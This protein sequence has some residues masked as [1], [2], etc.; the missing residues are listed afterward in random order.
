LDRG[1]LHS[2]FLND[3]VVLT[4]PARRMRATSISPKFKLLGLALRIHNQRRSTLWS[5]EI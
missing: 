5:P 2:D 3:L 1:D 4:A